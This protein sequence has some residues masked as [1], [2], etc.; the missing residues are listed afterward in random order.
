MTFIKTYIPFIIFNLIIFCNFGTTQ[1]SYLI[2]KKNKKIRVIFPPI[3]KKII[4]LQLL[5]KRNKFDKKKN[6]TKVK[7]NLKNLNS[8]TENP[9]RLKDKKLR[10]IYKPNQKNLNQDDIIK[11]IEISDNLNKESILTIKS[12]A[13]KNT[14]QG[15]SEARRLS[16][17]RALE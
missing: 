13:S 2:K 16:L 17:S 11:I 14:N 12:Y 4:S 9:I 1:E 8:K 5:K 7:K 6:N 15:S 3:Q 10:V